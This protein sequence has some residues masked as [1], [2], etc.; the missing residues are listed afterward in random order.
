[1]SSSI[2]EELM[3]LQVT[4]EGSTGILCA[5]GLFQMKLL[6]G[7]DFPAFPPT[8]EEPPD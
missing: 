2:E 7:K 8:Q 4:M 1:M 3:N 6:L 5:W